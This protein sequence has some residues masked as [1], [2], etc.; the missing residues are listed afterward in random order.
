MDP[1][2]AAAAM[3]DIR[4]AQHTVNTGVCPGTDTAAAGH[5]ERWR[6]FCAGLAIDPILGSFADPVTILQ[7]FAVRYRSGSNA[8][9][10]KP[11]RARTVEG[12]LR[13][14]GQAIAA[15]GG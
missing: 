10:K 9:N 3:R 8:T 1:A 7:I 6:T 13:A 15:V 2:V 5:W 11:V 4:I 12:A 14:V